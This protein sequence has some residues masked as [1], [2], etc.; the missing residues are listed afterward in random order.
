M[1]YTQSEKEI[2]RLC[3]YTNLQPLWA[4][5]NLSKGN[6]INLV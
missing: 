2:Y 5:E 6:K 4:T 3:H 1:T